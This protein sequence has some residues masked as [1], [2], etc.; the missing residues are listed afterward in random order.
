[1]SGPLPPETR[2]WSPPPGALRVGRL[3]RA[4]AQFI[5]ADGTAS[6]WSEAVE[7]TA[8]EPDLGGAAWA[9][10]DVSELMFDPA[11]DGFEFLELANRNP[12][13]S[14]D[15][16]GARF[17]NGIEFAFAPATRL[18]PG[19]HVLL[20]RTTNAPAFRTFHSLPDPVRIL[21]SYAGGLANEGETVA[22]RAAA[23]SSQELRFTYGVG[24]AWPTGVNGTGR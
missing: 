24:G 6:A 20:I 11:P 3:Y 7:F 5:D 22:I 9:D 8:G 2:G 21:G 13:Q 15:L 16:S 12:T 4:R 17:V 14:L 23:G 18:S 10:L 19:E 1:M